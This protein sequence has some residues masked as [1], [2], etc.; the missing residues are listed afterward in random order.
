M[1]GQFTFYVSD[2]RAFAGSRLLLCAFL[3]ALG[4][5]LEAVGVVALVPLFSAAIGDGGRFGGVSLDQIFADFGLETALAKALAVTAAFLALIVLRA[6][7]IY[8]RDVY[9]R[10][11]TLEYV[12]HWRRILFDAIRHA[13]WKA[14]VAQRRADLE[15]TVLSDV[16]RLAIGHDRLMRCGATIAVVVAQLA[17]LA[18]LSPAM[19]VFVI[20]LLGT[21]YWLGMPML[22]RANRR[23]TGMTGTGRHLH[24]TLGNLLSGQKLARL[25]NAEEAFNRELIAATDLVRENQLS[26]TR[27]QSAMRGTLQLVS[28]GAVAATLLTGFFAMDLS[29]PVLLVVVIIVVRIAGS[30]QQ[31]LQA[32]EAIASMLPALAAMRE[33]LTALGGEAAPAPAPARPSTL[34]RRSGPASIAVEEV[35]Y[36]HREGEWTL[37]G[38][39]LHAQPGEFVA[40]AGPSGVGKTTLLDIATGLLPATRGSVRVDGEKLHSE[41]DWRR[42]REDIAYLPQDPF[43]FDATIAENLRWFT[44]APGPDDIDEAL[45]RAEMGE[46]IAALPDGLETRVGERGQALSGGERQRLCLARALLAKPRLLIL[47]EALSAV[48]EEGAD[49]IVARLAD[50]SGRPTLIYVTHRSQGWSFA[51]RVVE[52]AAP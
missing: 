20:A 28:A 37:R 45:D 21:F 13:P 19:L 47:D 48:D 52:L 25:N 35:W 46:A 5:V 22:R 11:L 51:D 44:A 6:L 7:T 42:W 36:A 50:H 24:G 41:A 38:A 29:L 34:A 40:L 32:A 1:L 16:S 15:H 30:G 3:V 2:F 12:D 17:V 31:I 26:F 14:I 9:L 27:L 10:R 4:A 49:R 8:H 33:T 43:L 18:A 39:S 23:G